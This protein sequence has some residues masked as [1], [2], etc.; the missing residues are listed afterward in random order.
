MA[1]KK[2]YEKSLKE[3]DTLLKN[4]LVR[5]GVEEAD[6]LMD[7]D[8]VD[9]GYVQFTYKGKAWIFERTKEIAEKHGELLKN[10]KAAWAQL[11][12]G[13]Q[14]LVR[15]EK[16]GVFDFTSGRVVGLRELPAPVTVPSYFSILQFTEI[17][18]SLEELKKRYRELVK[19]AHPDNGGDPQRFQMLQQ[20]YDQAIKYFE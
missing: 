10:G 20:A 2:E 16:R 13:V 7:R 3:Y 12:Y 18:S 11:V 6:I 9:G 4:A 15:L 19:T 5:L 14:D 17:P 8:M 1:Q